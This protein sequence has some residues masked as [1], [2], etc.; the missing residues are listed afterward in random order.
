MPPGVGARNAKEC[1]EK[2]VQ[3]MH[4]KYTLLDPSTNTVY[5]L[6][7]QEKAAAFAGQKVTVKGTLDAAS[8]TIKVESIAAQ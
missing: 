3:Q 6:H 8:K 5:L 1:T 7:N 4:G 2:C